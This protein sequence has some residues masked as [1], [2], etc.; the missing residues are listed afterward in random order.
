MPPLKPGLE[1]VLSLTGR[2][3]IAT[4]LS[5]LDFRGLPL[6]G[7]GAVLAPAVLLRLAG[8]AGSVGVI[9]ASLV[10]RGTGPSERKLPLRGDL[11][12]HPRVQLARSRREDVCVYGDERELV[13]VARGLAGRTEISVEAMD[14]Q[15]YG[16]G[17]SLIHD[18]LSLLP[19][20]E[21]VFAAVSPGNARSLRAFLAVG[22]A[23]IGSEVL[24][25][26]HRDGATG[27]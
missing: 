20:G 6:D 12:G 7:F 9:D 21:P 22:F 17:R 27:R 14:G 1:A 10:A 4:E 26:V 15:A 24:I 3:Y 16:T 11:D 13:T 5:A 23:P 25:R 2:A 19:D 18:A 8:A